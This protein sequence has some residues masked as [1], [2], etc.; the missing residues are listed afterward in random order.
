MTARFAN[1]R[2]WQGRKTGNWIC[3]IYDR[4]GFQGVGIGRTKVEA[5]TRAYRTTGWNHKSLL[6]GRDELAIGLPD[7]LFSSR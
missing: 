2:I 7:A 3:E 1:A 6:T 4:S 5:E